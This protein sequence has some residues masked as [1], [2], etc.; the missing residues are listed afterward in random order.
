MLIV[1]GT[2]TSRFTKFVD[3]QGHI[4][5][6]HAQTGYKG[7]WTIGWREWTTMVI[8]DQDGKP[9]V[10]CEVLLLKR[11]ATLRSSNH[12]IFPLIDH[13]LLFTLSRMRI[14]LNW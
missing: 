8:W 5:P 7:A 1:V 6:N 14:L 4:T 2:F 12:V 11:Q 13:M 9:D 3:L 10:S